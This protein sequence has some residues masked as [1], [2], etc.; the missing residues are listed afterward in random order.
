MP[1]D[2][3]LDVGQPRRVGGLVDV[4]GPHDQGVLV[5]LGV[6]VLADAGRLETEFPEIAR[7]NPEPGK[8]RGRGDGAGLLH[9]RDVLAFYGDPKWDARLAAG[10]LRWE[11]ALVE[12]DGNW[13]LT[14]T[15]KAGADTLK[16]VN[17]NG[18]QR[19]NRPIVAMLP[20]RISSKVEI[21][22]GADL[23]PV[24]TDDFVLVPLP[25]GEVNEKYEVVFREVR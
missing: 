15:Q 20:R 6:V 14:I 12:K 19:G 22:S 10:P 23:K 8:T 18:T 3:G 1:H 24:I 9:D 11:Q 16:P 17:K 4:V 21:E 2:A 5:G 7:E 13:T 25:A